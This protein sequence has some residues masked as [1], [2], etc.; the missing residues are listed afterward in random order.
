MFWVWSILPGPRSSTER[1]P[2]NDQEQQSQAVKAV[3]ERTENP[4]E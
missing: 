2:E 3:D 4:Q 1:L